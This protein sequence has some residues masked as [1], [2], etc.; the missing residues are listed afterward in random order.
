MSYAPSFRGLR[1]YKKAL[2]NARIIYERTKRF[3]SYEQ[4]GLTDQIRRS[5]RAVCA[6]VVEAWSHRSYRGAFVNKLTQALGELTETQVWLDLCRT[7]GYITSDEHED[8][9]ESQE[10][11]AAMLYKMIHNPDLFC[12]RKEGSKHEP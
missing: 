5:S 3:P 6:L 8:L 10:H 1:V 12:G 4:F 2:E 9:N 7:S 11:V